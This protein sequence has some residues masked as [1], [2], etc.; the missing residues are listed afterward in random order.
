MAQ[1]NINTGTSPNDGTG[2]PLRTAFIKT[3]DNFT[4]LYTIS[5]SSTFPYSGSALITG[6]L[7]VTGSI[8]STSGL[9]TPRLNTSIISSPTGDSTITLDNNFQTFKI[10]T[11]NFLELGKQGGANPGLTSFNK[12]NEDIDFKIAGDTEAYLFYVNADTNRVGINTNSPQADFHVVGT[13]SASSLFAT[14]PDEDPEVN[15][16]FFQ[17]ESQ[18][19]SPGSSGFNVVCISQ[20][21]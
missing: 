15:H 3:E 10:G 6:S 8:S 7:G 11:L 2:D 1:Q 4:E 9:I 20:G 17:T 21:L 14:L 18:A 19:L 13:I 16:Q 12:N 5:T